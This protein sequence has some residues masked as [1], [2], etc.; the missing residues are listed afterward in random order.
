MVYCLKI[1]TC[2]LNVKWN[3]WPGSAMT[4]ICLIWICFD[5]NLQVKF[6][7]GSTST[8]AW[9]GSMFSLIPVSNALVGLCKWITSPRILSDP[10]EFWGISG[11]WEFQFK[12]EHGLIHGWSGSVPT[13]QAAKKCSTW[14][15]T[16]HD[17]LWPRSVLTWTY[18]SDHG[19]ICGSAIGL[20]Y[21]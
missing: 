1:L 4:W 2:D 5:L 17:P 15:C 13:G 8:C 20:V 16:D 12:A 10:E 3:L 7:V 11:Q 14:I 9:P 21:K 18:R 19:S 6:Q